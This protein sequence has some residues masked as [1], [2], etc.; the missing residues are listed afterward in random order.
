MGAT[1]SRAD[2]STTNSTPDATTS[3]EPPTP[4]TP[5]TTR[6]MTQSDS[7]AESKSESESTSS[8]KSSDKNPNDK[9]NFF[10][11][12][13]TDKPWWKN[14]ERS[15]LPNPGSYEE[16]NQEAT[17]ILRP[18]LVQG[19]LFNFNAPLSQSFALGN[20]VEMGAADNPGA[21][22]FNANY[23]TNR[24]VMI[25]RTTPSDGRVHGRIFV[26]HTPSLTSKVTADVGIEPDSSK[27]SWD[28]DYRSADSCS[29][30]KFA[31][32]GV[33]AVSYLQSV[34]P[35]LALGGEG[36]YQ[37]QSGFSALTFAGKYS[38]GPGTASLS[39]ASFGPVIAS[40]VHRINPRV[41]FASELFIDGRTRDSH[42]TVGYRFDLK[43]A[44][45]V[46][47]LDS[48]GRVAATLEE[49]INPALSLTLSGELDH[50]KQDYKFGFGVNI[51]GG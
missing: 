18:N 48:A 8:S 46:G 7:S 50:A 24:L 41:A 4:L 2:A 51:G 26:N 27:G 32:G 25:S 10:I 17:S 1:Y 20:S 11:P 34:T 15:E 47:H 28:L 19:L 16:I 9:S 43:N 23:Y 36:F 12:K 37:G 49:R 21:F 39:L 5:F 45:V 30:L 31:S 44:T 14:I 35:W 22:A 29:Q 13:T 42:L 33:V 40:Y 38:H 6:F 3:S